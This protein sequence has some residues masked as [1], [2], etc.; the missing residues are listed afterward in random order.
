MRFV[1]VQSVTCEKLVM[2]IPVISKSQD[3]QLTFVQLVRWGSFK[4]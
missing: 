3:E 4:S 2:F 1:N